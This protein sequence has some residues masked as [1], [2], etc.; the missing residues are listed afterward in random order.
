VVRDRKLG[1]DGKLPSVGNTVDVANATW[2]NTIGAPELITVWKD[3]D[4]DAAQRA[5]YYARVIEIPTPRWTAYDAKRFG[6]TMPKEVPM[7]TTERAYTSPI[8]YTPEKLHVPGKGSRSRRI[9]PICRRQ[10]WS[11]AFSLSF[12]RPSWSSSSLC[13][14]RYCLIKS[15]SAHEFD[16]RVE[17]HTQILVGEDLGLFAAGDH[18]PV[19][20]QH[21]MRDFRRDLVNMMGDKNDTFAVV[22]EAT[23]N[24]QVLKTGFQ[25]EAARWLIQDQCVRI[26]NE[27]A[28]EQGRSFNCITPSMRMMWSARALSSGLNCW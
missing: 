21:H 13:R 11:A 7:T 22:H 5:F 9:L 25:V 4:F 24:I 14:S 3:P 23:H 6:V 1:A 15:V 26:V 20:Q 19:F 12:P 17:E 8:W 10:L 28:A 2:T 27:G 16:R 18:R